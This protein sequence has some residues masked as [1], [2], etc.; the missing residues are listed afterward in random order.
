MSTMRDG[1]MHSTRVALAV[2]AHARTF[3]AAGQW[4]W[5]LFAVLAGVFAAL[6]VVALL[7]VGSPA[8]DDRT[9]RL[10]D[11][12]DR[13]GPRR[14]PTRD[15]AKAN[16]PGTAARTA[17]A[18]A[19]RLLKSSSAERGLAQ[20]L[21]LAGVARDPAEWLLMGCCA[22]V[23]LA[24]VFT[25]L[26]GSILIGLLAGFSIGWA[27]MRLALSV[28]I[29]RR[30]AAFSDQLADI[31]Q[32]IA[33]SLKAG[34]S[35]PQALAAAVREGAHP[36]AGE[37]SRALA[38]A[39]LGI[40]LQVALEAVAN[41]MNSDDLRWV[42]MAIRI[43]REVGGNLAEILTSTAGTM[44]ER[45]SLHRHVRALSAE[46]RLSAYILIGLPVVTGLYLFSRDRSYEHPLYTTAAGLLMLGGSAVLFV[47]GV[48]WMRVVIKV[49][50]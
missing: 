33:G 3:A 48:L 20:R 32:L 6:L 2:A 16:V 22:C 43:Q 46:G 35:L 37:F 13:Y 39:R 14:V 23:V 24:A 7:V 47:A 12:I 4:P 30:R 49:E 41:R 29:S 8:R 45:A 34:F 11:Q 18:L 21:D 42:I 15:K 50:A 9:R 40:D 25:I 10:A 19:S 38:E 5:A 36:A 27:G 28:R 26:G 31:L 17:V 44:R 1:G